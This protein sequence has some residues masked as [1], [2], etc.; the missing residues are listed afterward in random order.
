VLKSPKE[1]NRSRG[2]KRGILPLEESPHPSKDG[3]S[4]NLGDPNVWAKASGYGLLQ[5]GGLQRV[6]EESK[7]KRKPRGDSLG[8]WGKGQKENKREGNRFLGE[9]WRVR[10]TSGYFI[11]L[12]KSVTN[13]D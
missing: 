13:G 12:D 8:G 10:K 2:V 4:E 5:N 7:K 6:L 3:Q 9:Y 11:M 1:K